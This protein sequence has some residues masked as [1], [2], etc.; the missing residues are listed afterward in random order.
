MLSLPFR[1]SRHPM[2]AARRC[3]PLRAPAC[4]VERREHRRPLRADRL[5]DPLAPVEDR[6]PVLGEIG[7]GGA[8]G[9]PG[10]RLVPE[11]GEERRAAGRSR[12]SAPS[13]GSPAD[14]RPTLPLR[15]RLISSIS[16]TNRRVLSASKLDGST[17]V[18]TASASAISFSALPPRERARRVDHEPV[19]A[20]GRLADVA[21]MR[22]VEAPDRRDRSAAAR[23]ASAAPISAGPRRP[24]PPPRRAKP[25]P[26]RS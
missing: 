16:R 18:I 25:A 19:D 15:T 23:E 20:L 4:S 10:Q 9:D 11:R 2:R 1:P 3:K 5:V 17:G 8:V 24:A 26:R 6:E 14:A 12:G 22:P 21:R 7:V 13:R